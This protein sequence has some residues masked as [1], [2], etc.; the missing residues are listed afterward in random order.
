MVHYVQL[1]TQLGQPPTNHSV[2]NALTSWM[3]FNNTPSLEL[4]LQWKVIKNCFLFSQL[5]SRHRQDV[6]DA[7][8]VTLPLL[9]QSL[10]DPTYTATFLTATNNYL[11][12]HQKCFRF[13][14]ILRGTSIQQTFSGKLYQQKCAVPSCYTWVDVGLPYCKAHLASEMRL[15]LKPS[16]IQS[17]GLGVYAFQPSSHGGRRSKAVF[18]R[19]EKICEYFG[20]KLSLQEVERRYGSR[21]AD[22]TE[23]TAP[24]VLEVEVNGRSN[25]Y[26]DGALKR[27]IGTMINHGEHDSNANCFFYKNQVY[28]KTRIYHG[29]ELLVSYGADYFRNNPDIQEFHE[30]KVCT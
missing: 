14:G 15:K 28:A 29:E 12:C 30:T 5:A 6:K 16:T 23:F 10:V 3:F 7:A 19:N 22:G 11:A 20:E 2:D 24:Y 18:Q 25:L 27:G 9:Q 13:Q 1:K 26:I 17:A 8:Q 21:F 4:L